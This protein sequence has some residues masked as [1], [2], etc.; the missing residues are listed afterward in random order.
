M[1][2]D[3][4][5]PSDFLGQM[6]N[7]FDSEVVGGA[8]GMGG[9]K[10]T[11][12]LIKRNTTQQLQKPNNQ[13]KT[14][15]DKQQ[16][17]DKLREFNFKNPLSEQNR[18]IS[19]DKKDDKKTKGD[20]ISIALITPLK[21]K[22]GSNGSGDNKGSGS[23]SFDK[24]TD[25]SKRK[26]FLTPQNFETVENDLTNILKAVNAEDDSSTDLDSNGKKQK[27]FKEVQGLFSMGSFTISFIPPSPV[28]LKRFQGI[29]NKVINTL[30]DTSK[31][32]KNTVGKFFTS[33]AII[34]IS[35]MPQ[36]PLVKRG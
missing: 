35:I 22:G 17:E 2:K 27:S 7:Q 24:K 14:F 16:R 31:M 9:N 13:N 8:F 3:I 18:E 36:T 21:G 1:V 15:F 28:L 4:T 6:E 5:P 29:Q 32:L 12:N 34:N 25:S 33:S 19:K 26:E 30:Q 23:N 20:K 11:A 10:V